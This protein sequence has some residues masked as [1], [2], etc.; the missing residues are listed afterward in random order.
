MKCFMAMKSVSREKTSRRKSTV[1]WLG[2]RWSVFIIFIIARGWLS[3]RKFRF[4]AAD[5]GSGR[6]AKIDLSRFRG[7]KRFQFF[8]REICRRDS[9][10]TCWISST[11]GN[12]FSRA[13]KE[14][15]LSFFL[16]AWSMAIG[17]RRRHFV[18]RPFLICLIK[19]FICF[20]FLL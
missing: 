4:R 2:S 12:N 8:E 15:L 17:N 3:R 18:A 7:G 14:I 5:C 10:I 16:R 1:T 19:L 20:R 13:L 9:E 6:W 11:I